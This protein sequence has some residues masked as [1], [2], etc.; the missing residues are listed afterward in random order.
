VVAVETEAEWQALCHALG[1]PALIGDPRFSSLEQRMQNQDAL[2]QIIAAWTSR[3]TPQEAMDT[4]QK[5]GIPAGAVQNPAEMLED[6]QLRHRRHFK[7]LE[8]PE[9]G[10][11][12]Y[13]NP[14]FQLSRTPAELR[15]PSPCVGQHNEYI[16]REV[17][18]IP[19]EEF[20]ELLV[21][22]ALE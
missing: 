10:P 6:P 1:Q 22:G 13:E 7:V 4:L 20:V 5:H 15:M 12:H 3:R 16:Y 21:E 2:D 8:H 9:I 14:P 11:Q 18:G 17:L 19:E